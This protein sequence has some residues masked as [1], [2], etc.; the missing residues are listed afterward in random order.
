MCIRDRVSTQSTW[1]NIFPMLRST[2]QFSSS[3][4]IG[5]DDSKKLMQIIQTLIDHQDSLEFRTP[6]DYQGLGLSDYPQ[7][8]QYPMDLGTTKKKL[9]SNKYN[10]LEQ[11]LDDVQMIWDNCKLYNAEGSWIYKIADKLEKY[12]K[13]LIKNYIPTLP[14]PTTRKLEINQ[15]ILPPEEPEEKEPQGLSFTDKNKF[16]S[17][18]KQLTEEQLGEIVAMIQSNCPQAYK[19]IEKDKCQ[20]LVDNLNMD[21]V[22]KINEKIEEWQVGSVGEEAKKKIKTNSSN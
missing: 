3:T 1:G 14:T 11:C 15:S 8:I 9:S 5:K 16:S 18:M 7:V 12:F 4:P 21:I 20:I 6:V 22:K 2:L 19:D 10:T 17:K 13:K